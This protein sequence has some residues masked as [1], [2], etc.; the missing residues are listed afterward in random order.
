MGDGEAEDSAVNSSDHLSV[1]FFLTV[2][3]VNSDPEVRSSRRLH[4]VA[5]YFSA[6]LNLWIR[7]YHWIVLLI[8]YAQ[9]PKFEVFYVGLCWNYVLFHVLMRRQNVTTIPN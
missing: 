6:K 2:T 5:L 3:V 9:F 7:I 1:I 8:Y 4:H